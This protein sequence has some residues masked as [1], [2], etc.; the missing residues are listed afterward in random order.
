MLQ[1]F[2]LVFL[3]HV[4]AVL[5]S[6]YGTCNSPNVT[7]VQ[8]SGLQELQNAISCA[9]SNTGRKYTMEVTSDIVVQRGGGYLGTSPVH[10]DSPAAYHSGLFVA[11][12]AS[13]AI[14]GT[15]VVGRRVKL[16]GPNFRRILYIGSLARVSLGNI[17]FSGGYLDGLVPE[18]ERLGGAVYIGRN[19]SVNMTS[20]KFSNNRAKPN[21]H[22]AAIFIDYGA[23]V[24]M[25]GMSFVNNEGTYGGAIALRSA[26]LTV[27][28]S[29]FSSND[30]NYGGA[31]YAQLSG[32]F[33]SNSPRNW[34]TAVK[35][36]FERNSAINKGGALAISG[37]YCTLKTCTFRNNAALD[38]LYSY[39]EG[40]AIQFGTGSEITMAK[41][42]VELNSA[43]IGGAFSS[44][45]T[46]GTSWLRV[47]D[48][49]TR[50]VGNTPSQSCSNG[51][52]IQQDLTA[53][54]NGVRVCAMCPSGR[55][56]YDSG[57]FL[58]S[59]PA[60]QE[61]HFSESGGIC[62]NCSSGTFRNS[63]ASGT[64]RPCSKGT[65]QDA[66]GS[67]WCKPCPAGTYGA[68]N[69]LVSALECEPC[70]PGKFSSASSATSCK[71]C[72]QGTYQ[73]V[74]GSTRCKD[75]P[76]GTYSD[77]QA[78]LQCTA[79]G[80]GRFS[81]RSSAQFCDLCP[82]G[83]YQ[84]TTGGVQ[85][86]GCP[87]GTFGDSSGLPSLARCKSC[88]PGSFSSNLSSSSC[89][90]CPL[91]TFQDLSGSTE[92][93]PCLNRSFAHSRGMAQ[94]IVCPEGT[95]YDAQLAAGGPPV[96]PC[97][98]C[99]AGTYRDNILTN[100]EAD[101]QC[102]RCSPGKSSLEVGAVSSSTCKTCAAGTVWRKLGML[103]FLGN[104]CLVRHDGILILYDFS[105]G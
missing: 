34:I 88:A 65:Y 63:E 5:G 33:G 94:C 104:I 8:I 91:G 95:V 24:T 19:A 4:N 41:S 90:L 39:G 69:G 87:E 16:K 77:M 13:V 56:T 92:C 76:M 53:F 26:T 6:Q 62:T 57:H 73:N 32:G 99:R 40:G 21:G 49:D 23:V 55:T 43:R 84:N 74:S 82:K 105:Q 75:C 89:T 101:N 14:N 42:T 61:A 51:S 28:N 3:L 80:A 37:V 103:I 100:T 7:G 25:E 98:A 12:H 64:C 85:C 52:Y 45:D 30:G 9:N 20:C 47:V 22:G 46:T 59:C 79:C 48:A 18:D 27:I 50:L 54:Q 70:A 36:T 38:T 102:T 81:A 35:C 67:T 58:C 72:S 97:Q 78:S 10:A 29:T 11:S 1:A 31:I 96:Y 17:E 15:G 83:K 68:R 44:G 93:K 2:V 66:S 60:G 86:T 71:L